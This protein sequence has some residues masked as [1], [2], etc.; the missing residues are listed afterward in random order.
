M[1]KMFSRRRVLEYRGHRETPSAGL[2][3]ASVLAGP[4][5]KIRP[6]EIHNILE[7][8]Y[9]KS[10]NCTPTCCGGPLSCAELGEPARIDQD[11]DMGCRTRSRPAR[12]LSISICGWGLS[13]RRNPK[14][15]PWKTA[16][17]TYP[18]RCLQ[19]CY[20]HFAARRYSATRGTTGR[21]SPC[22]ERFSTAKRF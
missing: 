7:W 15:M 19:S 10:T 12:T 6:Q 1:A 13:A 8:T 20:R 9:W 14:T 4:N 3:E 11:L 2:G 5:Q 17:L 22:S 21:R 18:G 16:Y